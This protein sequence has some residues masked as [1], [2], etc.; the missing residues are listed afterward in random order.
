MIRKL[1]KFAVGI[2]VLY[3]ALTAGLVTVMRRPIVF[4]E[5]MRHVPEPV[6]MVFPFKPLWYLVR[7]G[8]VKVGDAAPEFN[9]PTA[10][11]KSSVS[12][13]AFRGKMPVVLI[14]GSYT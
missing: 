5:V 7:A 8:R 1:R 13:V 6:M 3:L 9:L 10:D 11:R 14:F 12:L 4:G 2:A